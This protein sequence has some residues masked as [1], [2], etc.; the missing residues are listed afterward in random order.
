[1]RLTD[2]DLVARSTGV[3]GDRSGDR[4]T[5]RDVLLLA[6]RFVEVGC[7]ERIGRHAR[8][9]TRSAG[10]LRPA[11]SD[12]LAQAGE[13]CSSPKT[14]ESYRACHD[15][16]MMFSLTPMVVQLRS[17]FAL[18]MRTRVTAPVPFCVSST[19]TL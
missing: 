14:S 2:R 15:A 13:P 9:P 11:R 5:G 17:P 1:M 19:R 3:P 8:E 10:S 18:S 12:R 16:S 6:G 7:D 4:D